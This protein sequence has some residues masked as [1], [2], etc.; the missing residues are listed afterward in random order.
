MNI[1]PKTSS[2]FHAARINEY[3]LEAPDLIPS[4]ELSILSIVYGKITQTSLANDLEHFS[5]VR[6]FLLTKISDMCSHLSLGARHPA[7]TSSNLGKRGV[8]ERVRVRSVLQNS[9]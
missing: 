7:G 5:E 3:F 6:I 2:N 4:R 8:L 9:E 1:F